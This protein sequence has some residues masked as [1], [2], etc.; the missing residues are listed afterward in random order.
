MPRLMLHMHQLRKFIDNRN[1]F[2]EIYYGAKQEQDK[3][4]F[5]IGRAVDYGIKAHYNRDK[6]LYISA[7][8]QKL[9]DLNQTMVIAMVDGYIENYKD[10]YFKNI[11]TVSYRTPFQKFMIYASPDLVM[12]DYIEDE[13][14]GEIKTAANPDDH[15]AVDFQTMTYC[16]SKYKWDFKPP[17][18]IIKRILRKP[19]IHQKKD[20]TFEQFQV[21]LIQDY[22]DRPE[23]YYLSKSEEISLDQIKEFEKYLTQIC[24]ELY[25]CIKTQNKYK[26]WK[27]SKISWI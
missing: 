13:W 15:L 2:F 11:R 1:D 20:E 16:W 25:S 26:F 3:E 24:K 6:N 17:K 18:G 27:E 9:N 10:E 19:K 4:Y 22:I 12:D 21:R 8:F 7:D 5:Q 23:F 14:I